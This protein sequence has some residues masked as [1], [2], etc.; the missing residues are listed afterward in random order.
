MYVILG[1][2]TVSVGYYGLFCIA[3][4]FFKST[5]RALGAMDKVKKSSFV[6]LLPVYKEDDVIVE[7]V[8]K[9]L[10]QHYPKELYTIAVIADHLQPLTLEALR[11][12][13]IQLIEVRFEKS[14]KA[15]SLNLAFDHL[16]EYDLAVVLDCD[17][18][19]EEDFLLKANYAYVQ[20]GHLVIQAHR[21]AKNKEN[22]LAQLD[23][24]SEE[25]NNAMFRTGHQVLGLPAALIGS[26][27]VMEFNLY[28]EHMRAI[29]T[30]DGF[31][32]ELEL[33][34]IKDQSLPHNKIHYLD[35]AL[36]YDAKMSDNE[37]FKKQRTR[38]ILAQIKYALK[39]AADG[40]VQLFKGNFAYFD[41]VLQ[42][43]LPPRLILLGSLGVLLCFTP[44]IGL[45]YFVYTAGLFTAL[46]L[47]L[48]VALP[49]Q[50]R[51]YKTLYAFKKLPIT[52][53]LM[54]RALPGFRKIFE[55]FLPTSHQYFQKK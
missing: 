22:H 6:I 45:E 8:K 52:F 20:E 4:L 14:T 5:Q 16:D 3:S 24:I 12:L 35:D 40:W 47:F 19:I 31:D 49:R 30:I 9:A 37:V 15:K 23:G 54:C 39:N 32:K 28:R 18:H 1:Y 43:W 27:M 29:D 25:L 42:F 13:P 48:G 36:V 2:F 26:G 38:W 46:A 33:R 11:Q 44:W 10:Q 41:K 55:S 17:N 53:W 7:S 50:L 34:L 21:T 51:T